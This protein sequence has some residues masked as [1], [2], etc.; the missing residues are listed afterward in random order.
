MRRCANDLDQ[1][2]KGPPEAVELPHHQHVTAL[3]GGESTGKARPFDGRAGN[4]VILMDFLAA[5]R[6]ESLPLQIEILFFR[7]YPCVADIHANHF[8]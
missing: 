4:A 2:G 1:V 8:A 5:R 6:F 3:G 7:R